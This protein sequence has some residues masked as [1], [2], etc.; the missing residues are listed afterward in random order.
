MKLTIKDNNV[1][2]LE[3]NLKRLS[4]ESNHLTDLTTLFADLLPQVSNKLT[5]IVSNFTLDFDSKNFKL[6][7]SLSK[8][9]D[10]KV[11]STTFEA[12][13]DVLVSVPEG[14]N[15]NM[16]DYV[17]TLNSVHDQLF[18]T[19]SELL[20]EYNLILSRFITNKDD[21]TAL[22]DHTRLFKKTKEI[23]LSYV[24]ELDQYFDPSSDNSK[25]KL[26]T[27]IDRLGDLKDISSAVKTLERHVSSQKLRDITDGT[28]KAVELLDIIN[29][30]LEEGSTEGVSGNA[31]MNISEGAYELAELVSFMSVYRYRTQQAVSTI[32]NTLEQLNKIIP[33]F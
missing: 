12:Y 8:D 3:S 17:S 4:L 31:A 23:R 9:L 24:D 6:V 27:I 25:A 13:A 14:F 5:D 29:G 1:Q 16:L 10:S 33:K 15:G 19:A 32:V 21:K 7:S 26:I 28:A 2:S 11:K 18:K 30:S 22:T 20:G